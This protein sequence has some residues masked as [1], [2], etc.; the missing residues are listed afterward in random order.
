[1]ESV[2][3]KPLVRRDVLGPSVP[4]WDFAGLGG[5]GEEDEVGSAAKSSRRP[6]S[7]F[8]SGVAQLELARLRNTFT[9]DG[10]AR[11]ILSSGP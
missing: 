11:W 8:G 6:C 3:E 1:M 2:P 4:P 5:G 7:S 9:S 10:P